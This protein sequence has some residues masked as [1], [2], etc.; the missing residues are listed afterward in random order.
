MRRL[1]LIA[2]A[3]LLAVLAAIAPR[4]ARISAAQENPAPPFAQ[5]DPALA[6]KVPVIATIALPAGFTSEGWP[7]LW[8][9]GGALGVIARRSG[10][11]FLLG[12]GGLAFQ[13]QQV[14]APGDSPDDRN[15]VVL[16]L[17]EN[18]KQT[19][20]AIA[21][22]HPDD[23]HLDITVRNVSEN[24]PPHRLIRLDGHFLAAGLSWIDFATLALGIIPQPPTP[25]ATP[26]AILRASPTP[27]PTPAQPALK[28]GLYAVSLHR[29]S[30][31]R[32][33]EVH[34]AHRVDF[35]HS[36]WSPDGRYALVDSGAPPPVLIDRISLECEDLNIPA[37]QRFRLIGW[38]QDSARFLYA[39]SAAGNYLGRMSGFFEYDLASGQIQTIAVPAA[40]AIYLQG[41]M[42]AALG[43]RKLNPRLVATTPD[44]LLPAEVAL[45]DSRLSSI[46]IA[47][48]GFDTA[49]VALLNGGLAYSQI[50]EQLAIQLL[51]LDRAGPTPLIV[52]FF[53]ETRKV[54]PIAAAQAGSL[55]AMSWSPIGDLLAVLD[56]TATPPILTV[57]SP[58]LFGAQGP[59]GAPAQ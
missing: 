48:L 38:S 18:P 53:P 21:I 24:Q 58:P 50:A 51:F 42:I 39:L 28:A 34:C 37:D 30:P 52:G 7:P 40:A 22:G 12:Y 35:T 55:L 43:N 15:G 9:Q 23:G 13:Q 49:A 17:A 19:M 8:F 33:I 29:G 4:C 36:V 47:P 54:S 45:I 10:R 27:S 57:L 26:T 6:P 5:G 32:K 44:L 41:G 3:T 11:V 31:I 14:L 25:E 56:I 59:S 1:V 20:L 2:T 46:M 16:D